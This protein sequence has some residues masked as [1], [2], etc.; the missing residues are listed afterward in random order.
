MPYTV[1]YTPES[2]AQVTELYRYISAASSPEVAARYTDSIL[3]YC[4][5]LQSLP[6]R[7]IQRDDIAL[8]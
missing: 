4:E 1:I 8:V 7:G 5:S 6:Y 2:E 3:T